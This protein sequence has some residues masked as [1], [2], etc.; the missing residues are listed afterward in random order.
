M[1]I[2]KKVLALSATLVGCNV[3]LAVCA[4]LQIND[5]GGT[6]RLLSKNTII[7]VHVAGRINTGSKAILLR[8]HRHFSSQDP[9]EMAQFEKY[10][11]DRD[12]SV[13]EELNT[14]QKLILNSNELAL[15]SRI[16]SDLD[17]V[18]L[19]W[20]DAQPL[21]RSGKKAEA[22][23]LFARTGVKSAEDLDIAA[24]ELVASNKTESDRIGARAEVAVHNANVWLWSLLAA[25]FLLSGTLAAYLIRS[26]N[27][28]LRETIHGVNAGSSQVLK[29]AS[30]IS[31]SSRSLAEGATRQ[32]AALEETSAAGVQIS[33]TAARN[34][35]SCGSAAQLVATAAKRFH[36]SNQALHAMVTEMAEIDAASGKIS[37]II[38]S[39]DEIAF[40]TNI[41]ALNAA[42]EAARAG[43]A[44]MGFA[45]VAGEVRMLAQ[46]SAQAARDTS[47]LIE[48]SISKTRG[49]AQKIKDVAE[50][51]GSFGEITG[52]LKE[53]IEEIDL[54]SQEQAKGI[55]QVSKAIM[56][57]EQ[58]TQDTA[59]HAEEGAAASEELVSQSKS[60]QNTIDHLDAMVDR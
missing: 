37:Q 53:L 9:Q 41:L 58:L 43:E 13:H 6:A 2:G 38:R 40:Q 5:L 50:M 26:M 22:V 32:A 34:V 3:I 52:N 17:S 29:A 27:S 47:T 21:S 60:L 24:K 51:I 16:R 49:G 44:G 45:V 56:S 31:S 10:L 4:L 55:A 28:A 15:S 14:Y 18:L 20:G 35:D 19:A 39:I 42:V 30:M 7:S 54:G 11:N 33:S 36:D 57:L 8:I 12:K 25:S 59:A 46:R 48:A 23:D 1:T